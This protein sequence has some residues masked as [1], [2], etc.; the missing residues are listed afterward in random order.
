MDFKVSSLFVEIIWSKFVYLSKTFSVVLP[1][2]SF[3]IPYRQILS[4]QK[5]SYCQIKVIFLHIPAFSRRK[6][7][8][9]D[10]VG[11][12]KS[13][14]RHTTLKSDQVYS[15]FTHYREV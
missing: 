3:F 11:I 5:D 4:G 15:D 8:Y 2:N 13:S 9:I 1:L 14:P 6:E 10:M 12:P 7:F